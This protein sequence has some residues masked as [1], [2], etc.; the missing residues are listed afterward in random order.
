MALE[1][2]NTTLVCFGNVFKS[3]GSRQFQRRQIFCN[4]REREI[5]KDREKTNIQL[6]LVISKSKGPSET[7]R[8]IRTSTYQICRIEK[9]SNRTTKFHKQTCNLTPFC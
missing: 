8:D 6:T 7:V 1:T 9:N 5:E 3:G 2:I 4:E